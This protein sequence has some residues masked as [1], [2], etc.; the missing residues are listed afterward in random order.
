MAIVVTLH[1]SGGGHA[2]PPIPRHPAWQV[3]VAALQMRPETAVP[4]SASVA[5][6]HIPDARHAAP[7]PPGV[8]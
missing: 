1:V 3:F 8:Q 7:V 5:H 4:Q 2:L 6:P